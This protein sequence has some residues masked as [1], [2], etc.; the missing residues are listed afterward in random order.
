MINIINK[1]DCCGC[2]ACGDICGHDAITFV[3]DIEGFWYPEVDKNKCTDC[4]LCEK[5]C[6]IITP[7]KSKIER[8][9][10]PIVYAAYNIDDTVRIDS[11]SG[12]VFSVLAEKMFAENGYVGGAIYNEDHTV[13]HIVTKDN[14]LLPEIR[15]SKYL[16][17]YTESLY[18]DIKNLLKQGEKVLVC[19]T[20]CQIAALYNVL[21][22]DYDN[23][24]SCD[25]I[26][27]GVNS[28]KVFLKYMDML[29]RQYGAK[30]TKIKFKAKQWGWHNFSMRVNFANGKEYCKDRYHDLFFIGYLQKGNF[31]R[32]SC[33]ECKF[34]GFP[35]KAD[36]TLADFWGIEKIDLSMDQ[37]KG[38]SLVII[39]SEKGMR[40]WDTVQDIIISKQFT[41]EQAAI[42]NPAMNSPLKSAGSD[43]D[44]FFRALDKHPFEDVAQKFFPIPT[45]KN[46]IKKRLAPI[47][48]LLKTIRPMGLSLQTWYIFIWFNFFSSKVKTTNRFA[49]RPH[50][51]CRLDIDKSAKLTI[52]GSLTMGRKQVS[53]S[54]KET[55]LLLEP[56]AKMRIEGNYTMYADS[57]IRVVKN[58][59]LIIKSGFIN[60][61]VQITCAS[62]V[63]VGEGCVIARDVVIR[64]Y[65]GH[66]I[67][68]PD[69]KIAKPIIIGN[70]VWIGNRSMILKGVTIG[71][72]AIIAAGSI[73]TKDVPPQCIVAGVPAKVIK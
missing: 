63:S 59:E 2:N 48:T 23:L 68:I 57:Y 19:A 60:E 72:G 15:S 20:P 18:I 67:D 1:K 54:H 39:N 40:F 12:G 30:A 31:A 3:T 11:T 44:A 22:K 25:F 4:G 41:M 21:G 69:Y 42:G 26:C 7:N 65:D 38:T 8:F 71:D 13:K 66:T 14:N 45:M 53:T 34:K 16:Q 58:G 10:K 51:Y 32:P 64:D 61:G 17:S 9:E 55:R 29:E 37:D 50:K 33:Y 52:N 56:N 62:K 24:I 47:K 73:V 70:H 6:P 5:A 35:Q 49:F 28:P 36:I 27:R 46:N 43:K